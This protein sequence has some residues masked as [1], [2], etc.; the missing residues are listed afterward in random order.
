MLLNLHKELNGRFD[1]SGLHEHC[2][3][4][5]LV[6]K[7]MLELAKNYK[8]AVDEEDEMTPKQPAIKSVGQQNANVT[9]RNKWIQS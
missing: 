9:W 7:Q 4:N 2:K 6:L 5:D 3:Y 1:T 8:K